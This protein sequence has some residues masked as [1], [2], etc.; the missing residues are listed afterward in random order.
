MS[1]NRSLICLHTS[2]CG[3]SPAEHHFWPQL[4]PRKHG[5]TVQDES[6]PQLKRSSCSK[7]QS[8]ARM[9]LRCTGSAVGMAPCVEQTNSCV[10]SSTFPTAYPAMFAFQRPIH[11]ELTSKAVAR[12]TVVHPNMNCPEVCLSTWSCTRKLC[13]C[14]PCHV[15]LRVIHAHATFGS[16]VHGQAP[17]ERA[18][19]LLAWQAPRESAPWYHC[20][21]HWRHANT[22][23]AVQTHSAGSLPWRFCS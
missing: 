22:P 12:H 15:Q 8:F 18:R 11:I 9:M 20:D 7:A 14:S 19:R 1:R 23:L 10:R 21:S 6:C 4:M 3:C 5:C 17:R 13:R 2:E 16:I